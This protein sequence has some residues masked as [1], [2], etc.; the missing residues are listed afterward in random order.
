ME[1]A[2]EEE[3]VTESL[4]A[5]GAA[6]GA[7]AGFPA[8]AAPGETDTAAGGEEEA[9]RYV[10]DAEILAALRATRWNR[11]RA[12]ERLGVSRTTVW[13]RLKDMESKGG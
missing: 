1:R 7:R 5:E 10:S 9:P 3:P 2:R 11:T 13:R 4:A 6:A 8:P 12:A